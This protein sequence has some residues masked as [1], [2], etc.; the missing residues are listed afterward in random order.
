MHLV[1]THYIVSSEC[2]MLPFFLFIQAA[3]LPKLSRKKENVWKFKIP[4][5]I[6]IKPQYILYC[7][8]HWKNSLFIKTELKIYMFWRFLP[9]VKLSGLHELVLHVILRPL[10][11]EKSAPKKCSQ[12]GQKCYGSRRRMRVGACTE[13]LKIP[14]FIIES[15]FTLKKEPVQIFWSVFKKYI[16]L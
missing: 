10:V 1:T 13:R 11:Q 5:K 16:Y 3:A 9:L 4:A 14:V 12:F 2:R 6:A 7:F 8:K 15:Q